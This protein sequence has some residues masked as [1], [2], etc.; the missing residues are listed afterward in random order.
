MKRRVIEF[1]EV[2]DLT[3]QIPQ[4]PSPAAPVNDV[5]QANIDT[6]KKIIESIHLVDQQRLVLDQHRVALEIRRYELDVLG[7]QLSDLLYK[8]TH[9]TEN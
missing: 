1:N 9:T 3:S 5:E 2:S 4:K 8:L 7:Y 6:V